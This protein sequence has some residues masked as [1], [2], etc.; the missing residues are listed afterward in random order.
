MEIRKLNEDF[1]KAKIIIGKSEAI[2]VIKDFIRRV[3]KINYSILITGE[4][5]VGKELIARKIHELSERK[6][7]PFIAINC[8]NLPENLIESELFGYRKGAF[9]DA[10]SD[11]MGLIEQACSGIIF[12]DEVSE[13]PFHLQAKLLRVIEN[14][15]IRR[16]GEIKPKEIDVRFIFATNNDLKKNI[17]EGRFRKDLYYRISTLELNIPPLRDRRE[18]ISLLAKHI[19]KEENK[20]NNNDKKFS[21]EVLNILLEYDYPGNIRELENIIKRLYVLSSGDEIE[22]EYLRL[23]LQEDKKESSISEIL[24]K[25]MTIKKRSYWEV[26]H[27]PF[28]K[29]E[30]NRR[31]VTEVLAIGLKRTNGSYKKL[32]PIFNINEEHHNYKRFIGIIRTHGFKVS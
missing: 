12:F 4:T 3:A 26:V 2:E 21:P 17:K 18:D 24:F 28:L 19:L 27:N 31:E 6:D 20:R 29:R 22:S 25:E 11:K 32:L 14:K 9:T 30:L 5:G 15:E 23:N 1:N 8:A 7:K 16:L 13:L 10:K